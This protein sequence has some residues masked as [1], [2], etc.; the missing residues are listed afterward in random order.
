MTWLNHKPPAAKQ[1]MWFY[2]NTGAEAK[3][4]SYIWMSK[5]M[6][7]GFL[8]HYNQEYS[9][10]YPAPVESPGQVISCPEGKH[11]HGGLR[12]QLELIQHWENPAN[13]FKHSL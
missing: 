2:S 12:V 7:Q 9:G 13:L 8:E 5:E 1:N 4:S 6:Y 11:G 3:T 10:S